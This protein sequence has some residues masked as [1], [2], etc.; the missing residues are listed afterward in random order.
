MVTS[1]QLKQS[2]IANN[3]TDWFPFECGV[4]GCK[5]GYLFESGNVIFDGACDC[6]NL[7]S[8]RFETYDSLINL[9]NNGSDKFKEEFKQY[10]KLD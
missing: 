2:I 9:Y 6:C 5:Y 1:E 7:N 8:T 10:F 4:C 3:I